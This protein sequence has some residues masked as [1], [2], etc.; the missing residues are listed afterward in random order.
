V[1]SH[2]I[3]DA[4]IYCGTG[5]RGHWYSDHLG[6]VQ[7]RLSSAASDADLVALRE[8]IADE[9]PSEDPD[10]EGLDHVPG[11]LTQQTREPYNRPT[12]AVADRPIDELEFEDVQLEDYESHPGLDFAV[13]E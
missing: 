1:F 4:H 2:T 8:W 7:D 5:E 9:A 3:V 10:E 13:A 11:L 12:I 6:A